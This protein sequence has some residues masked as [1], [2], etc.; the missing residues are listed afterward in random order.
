MK[1]I[2][3]NM[4]TNEEVEDFMAEEYALNELGVTITPKGKNGELTI[5]QLENI[6]ETVDWFFSGNWIKEK[7]EED[8][9]N[10][11]DEFDLEKMAV[12]SDMMY[13]EKKDRKMG[14]N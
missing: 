5:R 2:Y 1:Y 12:L 13:D 4:K 8:E 14:L 9:I 7:V 11:E 10:D 3:R 6:S